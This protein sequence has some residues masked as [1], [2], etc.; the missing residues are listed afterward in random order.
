[1]IEKNT[2]G[3]AM[4]TMEAATIVTSGPGPEAGS[5]LTSPEASS[6]VTGVTGPRPGPEDISRWARLSTQSF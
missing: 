6:R 3:S 5:L 4:R 1:M 2:R